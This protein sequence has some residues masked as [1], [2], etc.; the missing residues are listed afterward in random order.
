M[1]MNMGDQF[2]SQCNTKWCCEG[3]RCGGNTKGF[4]DPSMYGKEVAGC[5]PDATPNPPPNTVWVGP[6]T[7]P[8]QC[9]Q[10]DVLGGCASNSFFDN[11][12]NTEYT[13]AFVVDQTGIYSY[14]WLSKLSVWPGISQYTAGDVLTSVRP[15]QRPTKTS[16]PCLDSDDFCLLYHPTSTGETGCVTAGGDP[17]FLQGMGVA[18]AEGKN[19]WNLMSDTGQWWNYDASILNKRIKL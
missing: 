1:G 12:P 8:S 3:N 16:P 18:V 11:D 14:R 7:D 13:F 2:A 19:W 17:T 10:Y 6:T 4:I 15:A 9:S 5:Q